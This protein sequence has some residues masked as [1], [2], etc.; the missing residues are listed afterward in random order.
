MLFS[1]WLRLLDIGWTLPTTKLGT[2]H[3]TSIPQAQWLLLIEWRS[4][5]TP[6]KNDPPHATAKLIVFS[7]ESRR[8]TI[9]LEPRFLRPLVDPYSLIPDPT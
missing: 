8:N 3:M 7:G 9:G 6:T 5:R 2:L 1:I 4:T